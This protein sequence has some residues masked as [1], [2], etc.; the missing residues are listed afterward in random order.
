MKLTVATCQFPVG[1][2]VRRNTRAV[3]RQMKS[4]RQRGAD[5]AHFCECSLSGYAG[6]DMPSYRGFDWDALREGSER[7]LALVR[8]L[9]LWVLLSTLDTREPLYDST[10]AWRGRAMRGALHTGRLVRDARSRN[11]QQL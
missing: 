9:R 7:V 1:S 3:L 4:A 5:V 11:R 2:D 10:V 8:E 6:A